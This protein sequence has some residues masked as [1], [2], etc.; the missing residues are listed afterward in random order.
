MQRRT[1]STLGDAEYMS[2]YYAESLRL[3]TLLAESASL[4]QVAGILL[5]H[6]LS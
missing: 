3:I 2:R 1:T 5:A 6:A 4:S